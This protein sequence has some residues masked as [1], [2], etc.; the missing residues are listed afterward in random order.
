MEE[1]KKR[2]YWADYTKAF[3]IWLMVVCHFGLRPKGLVDFIYIFHMPVFFLVSG[4]FDKGEPFSM[5]I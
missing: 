1:T 3:A 2:Q 4:Y 5:D